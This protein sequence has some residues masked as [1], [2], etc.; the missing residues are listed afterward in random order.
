MARDPRVAVVFDRLV[1]DD[2][3]PAVSA[4]GLDR[5]LVDLAADPTTAAEHDRILAAV[6]ELARRADG[7]LASLAPGEVEALIAGL[8]PV[9]RDVLVQAAARAY[10]GDGLGAGARMIGYRA[11]PGRGPGAPVGEPVA[12]RSW[13]K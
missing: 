7:D 11:Q 13:P 2:G 6:E 10:Y 9:T 12:G 4:A 1:P 8:D 3:W 5:Y